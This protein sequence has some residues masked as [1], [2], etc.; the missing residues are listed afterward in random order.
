[1]TLFTFRNIP[2]ILKRSALLLVLWVF[3]SM[4]VQ[5]GFTVS[6][7]ISPVLL[8]CAFVSLVVHEYAH[9]I[10]AQAFG[11]TC[12]RID[13]MVLGGQAHISDFLKP[14]PREEFWIT[15]FGPLSNIVL[16][17]IT[18][19][20]FVVTPYDLNTETLLGIIGGEV[21]TFSIV[22]FVLNLFLVLN[23]VLA[24]FNLL[25]MFPMDGGRILRSLMSKWFGFKRGTQYT[26]LLSMALC[27]NIG[28]WALSSFNVLLFAIA[29]YIGIAS[30]VQFKTL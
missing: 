12:D 20:I 15:V 23:V 17:L 21:Q 22:S 24:A 29:L 11:K 18:I 16:A 30:Y 5:N 2:L 26:T 27:A 13:V 19:F 1:M 6:L 3:V 10:T 14:E 7:I 4:Y 9:A 28:I 25:P 8:A